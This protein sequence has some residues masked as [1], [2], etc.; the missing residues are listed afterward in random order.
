[1]D[2]GAAKAEHFGRGV[3]ELVSFP[4]EMPTPSTELALGALASA[5]VGTWHFDTATGLTSWD[6]IASRILGYQP[7]AHAS[8]G[9]GP[10]FPDDQALLQGQL[11]RCLR[12]GEPYDIEFRGVQA[13]GEVRWLHAIAGP[14]TTSAD[15]TRQVAGIVIDVTAR[16]AAIEKLR[17][18]EER[19]QIVSRAATD[20]VFEW[21]I[22]AD[23]L[24]WNEAAVNWLQYRPLDL[25]SPAEIRRWL[26]PDERN[27]LSQQFRRASVGGE[28]TCTLEH[29]LLRGDRSF[30]DIVN[31]LHF[32]RDEQ[33]QPVRIIAT[34]RDVTNLKRADAALRDSEALNR[35]IVEASTDV[36]KLLD[37][38]GRLIFMN[39]GGSSALGIEDATL[40]YGKDWAAL[41]PQPARKA[42]RAATAT[43]R[44]G[45]IGR[46]SKAC[47]TMS[48]E[49]KWWDVVVSPVLGSDGRPTKLVAISRDITERKEAVERLAWS[50]SHDALT[51]LA[52]R[53]FFHA[54]LDR[55]LAT[56]HE[57]KSRFGLLLFDLD[58][59]KQINDTLGHDA[60]DAVLTT[61]ASRLGQSLSG[62][63][64]VGRLGGDEFAAIVQV[65]DEEGL[66]AAA[67][68]ILQRMRQP[69]VHA[70]KILDCPVTIGGVIFPEHGQNANELLKN[71]DIALYVAKSSRRGAATIFKASHR[72]QVQE[73][74]SMI[75]LARSA[76]ERRLI[77]PYYQ[78]KVLLND[79]TVHGFEA[80]LRWRD[81]RLGIQLPA[82][83][84]AAFE[85]LDLAKAI[86]DSMIEQVIVDMRSWLD[87][88]IRFGHVAV[89]AGAA[90]FR[91][92][93]FGESLLKRLDLAS[94][95][96]TFLQ[97]EV[98]ESVFLGRGAECVE[99]ALKLLSAAG[100][101]IALDDF[102]TGYASLRHLKQFPIDV[103]KIDQSFVRE[104]DCNED[105]AAIIE[106]V[107]HLGRSL[108]IDVIAEG[109]ETPAQER[110]LRELGCCYGQGFLYA[111]AIPN[112]SVVELLSANREHLRGGLKHPFPMAGNNPD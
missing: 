80:L 33:G 18:A 16:K 101:R 36:V 95:P 90:E 31:T 97:L 88:D 76:T 13:D 3:N 42:A 72:A 81:P 17:Q 50:A 30:A 109:I 49:H 94:I 96:T 15:G 10:V 43:A 57:A 93:D 28:A 67:E 100:V 32:I 37:L 38:D 40:F 91:H 65:A 8:G 60:G 25:G 84:A 74:L 1:M 66:A 112:T 89:N 82:T 48:G 44:E 77:V 86:S 55:T 26:H 2:L 71:A 9:M 68:E 107:L 103:I 27:F 79:G 104:M 12:D 73:R 54:S 87:R 5:G 92:D 64:A 22:K 63:S 70:G 111:E 98:T 51:E 102:G 23:F 14:P 41:W 61:F 108:K 110:R 47:P 39:N 69:F 53:T 85:D 4:S 105:D 7:V 56:A 52:N 21:D 78:P 11:E 59:F 34:M 106:A 99:R 45:G 6:A 29:R 35:S 20:L 58:D 46:F 19:H 62:E 75:G 24:S 83:I